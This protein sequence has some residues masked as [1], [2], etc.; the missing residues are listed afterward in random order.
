MKASEFGS[1]VFKHADNLQLLVPDNYMTRYFAGHKALQHFTELRTPATMGLYEKAIQHLTQVDV[2]LTL[3]DSRSEDVDE[4]LDAIGLRPF[5]DL[6][7]SVAAVDA[8]H[9]LSV[10]P[11]DLHGLLTARHYHDLHLYKYARK[12]HARLIAAWRFLK[13][14]QQQVLMVLVST[15]K[16]QTLQRSALQYQM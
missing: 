12:R 7:T 2:V 15:G 3:E 4:I 5:S 14:Q 6:D 9:N 1:V 13:Q 8:M 11:R 10:L 16:R